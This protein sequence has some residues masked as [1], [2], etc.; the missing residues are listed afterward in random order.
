MGSRL[1]QS[2]G[3]NNSGFGSNKDY[4]REAADLFSILVGVCVVLN[5]G[6]M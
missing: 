5:E 3:E 6:Q 4:K 1:I 2:V